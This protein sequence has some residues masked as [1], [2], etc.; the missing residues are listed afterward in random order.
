MQMVKFAKKFSAVF[1][2]CA[3]GV[4]ASVAHAEGKGNKKAKGK[5]QVETKETH[6]RDAGEL[7]YGLQQYSKKKG[8][9]PS[10][11]QTKKDKDEQLTH[12][13]EEGGKNVRS[14]GKGKKGQKS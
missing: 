7:P 1:I 13:L 11:L 10:G 8:T 6:G 2:V 4:T 9:L 12:G 14:A 3:M 5:Q